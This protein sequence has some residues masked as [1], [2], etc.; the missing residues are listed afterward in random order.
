MNINEINS[1]F[2][3]SII[4]IYI[5]KFYYNYLKYKNYKVNISDK[6]KLIDSTHLIGDY[7][8][9]GELNLKNKT[10]YWSYVLPKYNL[11][12]TYETRMLLNYG[13]KIENTNNSEQNLIKSL[14]IN[15]TI[16]LKE[17]LNLIFI[18]GL[19]IYLLKEKIDFIYKL[20]KKDKIIYYIIKNSTE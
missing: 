10:W 7:E 19:S 2:I 17:E 9:L 14:L 3:K 20:E 11:D 18:I 12:K 15:S 4:D 5:E 16:K 6:I 1:E 8:I 13:A